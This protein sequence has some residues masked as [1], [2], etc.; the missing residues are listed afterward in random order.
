MG[1]GKSAL[2]RLAAVKL[3]KKFIDLDEFISSR[4]KLSVREIFERFGEEKFR[5]IESRAVAEVSGKTG[6]VIATGGGVIL[7]EENIAALKQNGVIIYIYRPIGL[8]LK[9]LKETESRPLLKNSG[10][11]EIFEKR[12][13]LYEASA[14]YTVENIV[15]KSALRKIIKIYKNYIIKL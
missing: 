10:L 4:E 8:I 7:K 3:K 11:R 9:T 14:D 12:R 15:L 13:K 6:R 1:C 2:G 5:E